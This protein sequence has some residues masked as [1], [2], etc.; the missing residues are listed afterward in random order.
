ML[1]QV[2]GNSYKSSLTVRYCSCEMSRRGKCVEAE[3][4]VGG[5]LGAEVILSQGIG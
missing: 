4:Q 2:K 3:G 5:S 1:C